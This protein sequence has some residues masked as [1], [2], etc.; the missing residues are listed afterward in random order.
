MTTWKTEFPD[1]PNADMPKLPATFTDASWHNDACPNFETFS[2]EGERM[3]LFIDY[4][5][6]ANRQLDC[7]LKRFAVTRPES[8]LDDFNTD[9]L[10]EALAFIAGN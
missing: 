5:N 7:D 4:P 6:P 8:G 2:P 10:D 9:S 1:F 3:Y